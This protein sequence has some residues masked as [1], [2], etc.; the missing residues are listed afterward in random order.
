MLKTMGLVPN[1]L[2]SS[3]LPDSLARH[4]F[5]LLLSGVCLLAAVTH[6]AFLV[7][8]HQAGVQALVQAN[9]ASVLVYGLSALLLRR[10]RI[11]PAMLLM[12][13]EVLGHGVLAIATIGWDSGF[14]YYLLVIIPVMLV[15]QFNG[16]PVR[17]S[18]AMLLLL[19]YVG[20]DVHYRRAVPLY[21][22]DRDM[23]DHLHTFNMVSTVF[24]L[25]AFTVLYVHVISRA[26]ARLH[27]L[28]T[29]DSLTGLMN[30]RSM[31]AALEREQG[32]RQRLPHPVTLILVDI[33]HFKQLNDTHGHALGDWALQAVAEAL[34]KALREIDFVARW[35]GEEFLIALP[36]TDLLEAR[37]VAERL[38]SGVAAL[39]L[40]MSTPTQPLRLTATLGVSEVQGDESADAA[41]AR[42]DAA[43]YQGKR[44][45]RNRV[46][47]AA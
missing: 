37:L 31:L 29:T 36:N 45:G 11:V 38:R 7:L 41:I 4:A 2:P 5:A 46:E 6:L 47:L 16:W 8:F 1:P 20:L 24:L 10:E 26:E 39:D 15:S 9:V 23:L 28:A 30:R 22:M 14:H 40:P 33:D 3:L 12:L 44:A 19:A 17:L 32:L 18:A 35:G 42:A 21:A 34:R 13:A 25:S 43:L 27:E